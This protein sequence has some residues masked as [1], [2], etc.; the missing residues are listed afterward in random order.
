M[1]YEVFLPRVATQSA[2]LIRQSS[3]RPSFCPSV[4]LRYCGQSHRLT[5]FENNFMAD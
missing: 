2:V 1:S 4:T 5:Y 3:V